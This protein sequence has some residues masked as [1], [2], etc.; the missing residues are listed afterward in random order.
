MTTDRPESNALETVVLPTAGLSVSLEDF[1]S[2]GTQASSTS[3]DVSTLGFPS[4]DLFAMNLDDMIDRCG[5][6]GS[7]TASCIKSIKR[8]LA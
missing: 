7:D 8:H 6:M 5:N 2:F 4:G 1:A 3:S